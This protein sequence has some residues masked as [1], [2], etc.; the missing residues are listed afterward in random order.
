MLLDEFRDQDGKDVVHIVCLLLEWLVF[1]EVYFR[2]NERIP[3]NYD[4][5][6]DTDHSKED[7]ETYLSLGL[8]WD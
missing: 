4:I 6:D 3:Q 5:Y 8:V 1:D 7:F 2:L